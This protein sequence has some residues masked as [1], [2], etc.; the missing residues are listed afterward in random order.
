MKVKPNY[1]K[2]QEF[3]SLS[4]LPY[5]QYSQIRDWLPVTSLIKLVIDD[6]ELNDCIAYEEYEYWFENLYKQAQVFDFD[7]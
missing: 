7:I 3:V 2:G 5:K 1:Y 6:L 4:T